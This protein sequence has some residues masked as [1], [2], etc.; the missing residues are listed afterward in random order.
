MSERSKPPADPPSGDA[1]TIHVRRAKEGDAASVAWLVTRFSPLLLAQAS[2]R[3]GPELR[4]HCDPLDLVNDVW[5]V[6]L[7]RLPSLGAAG[8]RETPALLKFLST[9]LIYRTNNLARKHLRRDRAR[10]EGGGSSTTTEQDRLAELPA[11]TIG[12]LT[13]A[14]LAERKN[15]VT[16]AIEALDELDRRIVILRGIEQAPNEMVAAALEM[17]ASTVAHRFRRAL[18]KLRDRLPD[19][20]FADLAED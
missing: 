12:V 11:D 16:E 9:T 18:H 7:P 17:N 20:V 19:S 10:A 4:T 8:S 3:L 15:A 13:A 5:L 1:T 14:V 2:Y 6:A